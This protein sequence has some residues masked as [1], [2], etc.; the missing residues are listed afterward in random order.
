MAR[1]AA[2]RARV[3][4]HGGAR[5]FASPRATRRAGRPALASPQRGRAAS[6]ISEHL[7]M[8]VLCLFRIVAACYDRFLPG[9]QPCVC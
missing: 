9:C 8:S 2:A 5:I 7:R 1:L 4:G 3:F 6:V